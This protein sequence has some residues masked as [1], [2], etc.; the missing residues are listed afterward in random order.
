[1]TFSFLRHHFTIEIGCYRRRAFILTLTTLSLREIR[2]FGCSFRDLGHPVSC[3]EMVFWYGG[4]AAQIAHLPLQCMAGMRE[5]G[6]KVMFGA[7]GNVP[8]RR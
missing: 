2:V 8:W 3:D 5:T 6:A 1:M 7:G 4:V